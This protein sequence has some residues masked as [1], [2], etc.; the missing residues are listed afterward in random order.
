MEI[1]RR[2]FL[3]GSAGAVWAGLG[4]DLGRPVRAAEAAVVECGRLTSTICP[5]CAVGCGMIVA[6]AGGRVLHIEGD[7]DHPISAGSLCSK[8]S[9][10]IQV[11][12]NPRRVKTV[13]YRAPGAGE[14]VEKD[15]SWAISRIAGKIAE[16]R[17]AGFLITDKSGR[18]VRR[19]ES[20]AVLGGAALNNEECYLLGK[21][22]R[23][24][25]VVC[26]EHQARVCHSSTVA[27]LAATFGRGAMTNHFN[28]LAAA[29]VILVIGA[30]PAENHPIA[31]KW[32]AAARG[33]G[34]RLVHV[35][36][37]FTRT[38]AVADLYLPLRPGT[39]IALMGGLINHAL[40]NGLVDH[41]YL[42]ANTNVSFLVDPNYEFEDGRFGAIEEGRY[43]REHWQFQC[44]PSGRIRRDETL[45]DPNCVYQVLK[46]HFSRYTL[47]VVS[48][49]CGTP[50]AKLQQLAELFLAT[51]RAGRAGTI[52]Y[53]M[54]ATQHS[55]GTQIVRSYAI[56][57][58]L[59][60]N[61]GIAGGGINA[62]RGES[63]VQGSTDHGLMFDYLPGYLPSPTADLATFTE[64]ASRHA[65]PSVEPQDANPGNRRRE[66]L[67]SLLKAWWG[68]KAAAENDFGYSYLP[69][70]EGDC[71]YTAIFEAMLGG[72]IKGLVA[73]GQNPAVSSPDVEQSR[74]ALEKL[75][76]LVSVDLWETETAAFWKRPGAKPAEIGTEVF[77]LPAAASIEKT[78]SVT[79]SGR[80]AQWRYEAVAPLGESRSDLWILDRLARELKRHYLAGGV[81]PEPIAELAW[82]YGDPPAAEAVARE[83]A[84]ANWLYRGSIAPGASGDTENRM[85][86]RGRPKDGEDP[87]GLHSDWAWSWPNNTRVLYNRVGGPEADVPDGPPGSPPFAMLADGRAQLFAPSLVDGPLPEHYEPLESPA[88]NLLSPQQTSPLAAR[89]DLARLGDAKQ[90]PIVATT[91]RVGEH[92]QAGAM[93]RNLPWLVE[94]VPNAF[95][96]ISREL[97]KAKGIAEGD[98][99][100]IRSA[101]GEI[102]L[103]ALITGR[104]KPLV[105][106][107]RPV[108][109]IAIMWHFGYEGLATGPSGNV[110][111]PSAS[112]ANARIPEYKA[113]L[114]DVERVKPASSSQA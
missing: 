14:W 33:G 72:R 62:L 1:S 104:L 46:R 24:L 88:V 95:A 84:E 40:E 42:I 35:D 76:W 105:I 20:L 30:N 15:W 90:F 37:R 45:A 107:G 99:I 56:L 68:G 25:G 77:L 66:H 83:I 82:D 93:S 19:A 64:Y 12:D 23:A 101:R 92:W 18:T 57:Q 109:Q 3:G 97:A 28:D 6:S 4:I 58:L 32:I 8:G 86:R 31:M 71:S 26:L 21:L 2:T 111:T 79:N 54:G 49:V 10:F 55:T 61:I 60:G 7:P 43:T 91:C 67:K 103:R 27:G 65:V 44:E 85:A 29:D 108:E 13:K 70:H 9:A 51:H 73:W 96:E 75:D 47:D 36:P 100:T 34:A 112:D 74:R 16:T 78:G 38:S 17:D 59:L 94:L 69:K 80:W 5:Y 53:A 48:R 110:L 81:C 52:V 87:A 39:D 102:T 89:V 114:C 50:V 41:E 22:A 11:I 63:N 98:Q 113:F 106:D